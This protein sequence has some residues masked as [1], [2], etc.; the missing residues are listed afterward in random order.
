MPNATNKLETNADERR[1]SRMFGTGRGK[2]KN[3]ELNLQEIKTNY[4]QCEVCTSSDP[5]VCN[6]AFAEAMSQN[7]G[8]EKF[9][10]NAFRQW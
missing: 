4:C 3:V 6:E 5:G 7:N 1:M 9:F 8:I 2:R 10:L